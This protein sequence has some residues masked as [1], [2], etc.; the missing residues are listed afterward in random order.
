MDGPI[1]DGLV[2]ERYQRLRREADHW[3][4]MKT[5]TCQQ[6]SRR[7]RALVTLASWLIQSGQLLHA[8]GQ[9]LHTRYQPAT[10]YVLDQH[11]P[12]P[13]R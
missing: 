11:P 12:E 7:S 13:L 4:L 5:V 10:P 6:P 1:T 9:R 2:T 3:R 8:W